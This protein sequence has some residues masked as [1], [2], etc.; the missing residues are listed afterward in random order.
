MSPQGVVLA[1]GLSTR[2]GQDKALY[3]VDGVPLALRVAGALRGAGLEVVVVARDRR[4]EALGLPVL[5][6]PEAPTRHPLWG[7]AAALAVY[8]EV[9]L[10]PCDLPALDV[11]TVR[12]LL[13]APAPAVAWDGERVHPLLGRYGAGLQARAA[14]LA[15]EGGAARAFAEG[16][17]RVWVRAAAVGN[18]NR[19]G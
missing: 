7:V 9:L 14:A 12:A 6:E 15:A 19:P 1:G 8:P 3:A 13:A 17:A 16:A 10:A 18:L 4:L 5:L 2:F 11:P